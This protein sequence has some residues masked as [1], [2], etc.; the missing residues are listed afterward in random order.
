MAARRVRPATGKG[1][2]CRPTVTGWCSST[3]CGKLVQVKDGLVPTGVDFGRVE[4]VEFV[5]DTDDHVGVIEAK[6]V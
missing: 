1:S 6:L 3:F 4:L 2:A 5:S